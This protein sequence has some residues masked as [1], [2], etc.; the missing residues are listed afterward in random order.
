MQSPLTG[1]FPGDASGSLPADHE[2]NKAS[3]ETAKA[4][5]EPEEVPAFLR[6]VPQEQTKTLRCG[7]CSAMNFPTEWYCERCGAELAGM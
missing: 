1:T 6:D 4:E 2:Q 7:D 3:E 5:R